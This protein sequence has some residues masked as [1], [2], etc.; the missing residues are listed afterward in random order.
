VIRVW[1]LAL[2]VVALLSL[3]FPWPLAVGLLV[4]L[5]AVTRTRRDRGPRLF[6]SQMKDDIVRRD[7]ER[8]YY[9][10]DMTHDERDCP[11]GG[12]CPDCRQFDHVRAWAANGAT[13]LRNGRVSCAFCNSRKGAGTPAD[14]KAKVVAEWRR[15]HV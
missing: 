2:V 15:G 11:D 4:P 10:G 8:C 14:L 13:R 5:W 9:C 3:V 12:D 6:P 1:L 7:G